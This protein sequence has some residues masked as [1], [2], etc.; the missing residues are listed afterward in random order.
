[1]FYFLQASSY[2]KYNIA[3]IGRKVKLGDGE[4]KQVS[5]HKK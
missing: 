2:T 1:M 3:I 4:G 5:M